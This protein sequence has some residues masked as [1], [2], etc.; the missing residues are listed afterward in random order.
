MRRCRVGGQ[1]LLAVAPPVGLVLS[2]T[3]EDF[4]A[5]RP[6]VS[7][8]SPSSPACGPAPE[9][10][11][12]I[13]ERVGG[14]GPG[15]PRRRLRERSAKPWLADRGPRPCPVLARNMAIQPWPSPQRDENRTGVPGSAWL[16][17]GIHAAAIALVF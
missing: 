11:A 9:A 7:T 13:P 17:Q 14:L 8:T 4:G 10:G 12:V 2:L 15:N 5:S 1:T 6:E 3:Y 16:R